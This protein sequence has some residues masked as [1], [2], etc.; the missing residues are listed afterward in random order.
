MYC[1]YCGKELPNDSNFC[2]NC[3][4]K[5]KERNDLKFI[6]RSNFG[7]IDF[8]H[9]HKVIAYCYL[10]W[11]LLHI[12][13]YISSEKYDTWAFYP[14][15][16]SIS[17]IIEG[18]YY[19]LDFIRS[20]NHYDFT[21]FFVYTILIPLIIVTIVRSYPLI[22]DVCLNI[23]TKF[24]C[25]RE[26]NAK[27]AKEYQEW[28]SQLQQTNNTELTNQNSVEEIQNTIVVEQLSS[29]EEKEEDNDNQKLVI[30]EKPQSDIELE[31]NFSVKNEI[32]TMP[33]FRR[34]V[35]SIID[36]ILILIL[37]VIVSIII[38]PYGASGKLGTYHGLLNA[39]PNN[40]EYI[41]KAKMNRYQ[42]GEYYEGVDRY[43]QERARLTEEP[44]HLGS[45]LELDISVTFFFILFNLIYY[46]LFE[47]T[48]SASPGKRM[49]GGILLD[50][51]DDKIGFSKAL[52]RGLW[53]GVLMAGAYFLF[54]LTGGLSNM[55]VVLFFFFILDIS[56]LFTKKSLIDII[57]GT[58]YSKVNNK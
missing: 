24:N 41:D 22:K 35:G 47:S 54:H 46:I 11:L 7:V 39:S 52:I 13:L 19:E 26:E 33:L 57:S 28:K 44:P 18:Y 43:Y 3:G 36:K 25:W 53:G 20:M 58:I 31:N 12:T 10:A 38:S 30:Q 49:L 2:P 55:L 16:T 34:F 56:V 15:N 29:E 40:Y 27:K 45:T 21:E 50:S 6:N 1:R 17:G 51:S 9:K 42:T 14:F 8:I 37:F 23:R 48:M 32:Q 4:K 5:Q